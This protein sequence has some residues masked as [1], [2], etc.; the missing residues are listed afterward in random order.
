MSSNIL[1]RAFSISFS[2]SLL[3]RL[4][5]VSRLLE[6]TKLV[7]VVSRVL[8]EG[9]WLVVVLCWLV[10]VLRLQ[11]VCE[12][13]EATKLGVVVSRLLLERCWLVEVLRLQVV[14]M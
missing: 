5:V 12:L 13:L 2:S 6:A 10:V 8:L 7:M 1:L 4:Q 11:G 9:C 14:S 3:A